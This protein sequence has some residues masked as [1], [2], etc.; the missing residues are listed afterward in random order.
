M[1]QPW[2]GNTGMKPGL[3]ASCFMQLPEEGC[4]MVEREWTLLST[5]K[6]GTRSDRN[7]RRAH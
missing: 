7:V 4:Q 5:T 2:H 6:D 1:A 3:N